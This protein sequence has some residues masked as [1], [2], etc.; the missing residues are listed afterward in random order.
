[1]N[2]SRLIISPYNNH[3][4]QVLILTKRAIFNLFSKKY[5]TLVKKS[6]IMLLVVKKSAKRTFVEDIYK[7]ER[8][9]C[10]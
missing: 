9:D 5:L 8:G 6:Y 10:H 3:D 2:K 1:M 4:Y 7:N